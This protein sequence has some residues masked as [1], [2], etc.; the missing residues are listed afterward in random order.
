MDDDTY[1]DTRCSATF[2]IWESSSKFEKYAMI[3][4]IWDMFFFIFFA[5]E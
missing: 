3:P 1:S 2:N 5:R 4:E